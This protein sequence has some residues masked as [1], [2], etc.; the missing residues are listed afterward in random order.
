MRCISGTGDRNRGEDHRDVR[1]LPLIHLRGY[2]PEH[3]GRRLALSSRS[4]GTPCR[5][6][7]ALPATTDYPLLGSP[8]PPPGRASPLTNA[9]ILRSYLLNPPTYRWL[10][11]QVRDRWDIETPSRPWRTRRD[12]RDQPH[13]LASELRHSR[14]VRN[15]RP[16]RQAAG[17]RSQSDRSQLIGANRSTITHCSTST[18]SHP[19]SLSASGC[20]RRPCPLATASPRCIQSDERSTGSSSPATTPQASSR[21]CRLHLSSSRE[22]QPFPPPR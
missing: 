4:R 9:V 5:R 6:P 1:R 19:R 2:P 17:S 8:I 14:I 16:G 10:R 15:G 7:L 20:L 21:R 11:N 12:Q 18:I 22:C 13:T 3:S